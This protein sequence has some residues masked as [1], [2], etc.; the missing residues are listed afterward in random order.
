MKH[1]ESELLRALHA[2]AQNKKGRR[3]D[4]RARLALDEIWAA[5]RRVPHR[6][7]QGEYE[8]LVLARQLN[9][10]EENGHIAQ[11]K[12]RTPDKVSLPTGI[13]LRPTA[14]PKPPRPAMPAWHPDIYW[15][16]DA[17]PTA[18]A[19]QQ[20]AYTA[21]NAWLM[22]APD[23]FPV[24]LRER[25]LEIFGH[26]GDEDDFLMPEKTLDTLRSG[27]LFGDPG[28]LHQVLR[29]FTTHPP[30]LSEHFIEAVG[31]G[32]YQ[33]I[34]PGDLLLVVENSATWWSIVNTLPAVHRL[35]YV[36]WGLG[37]TFRASI[38]T[39]AQHTVTEIR[40]FGDLDLSGLRIPHG[41]SRTATQRGLPPVRP[42]NKLYT[43]LLELGTA[44]Q[45]K[46]PPAA[47]HEATD[48]T[49][50]LPE[51]LRPKAADVITRGRRLAQEWVGYRHLSRTDTWHSDV[52]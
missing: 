39:L 25:A 12:Q 1:K 28:K 22:S 11:F 19:R 43:A 50:W 17:W 9:T 32:Y 2:E 15:L 26:H 42:A 45:G 14:A 7:P 16:A 41:A 38:N 36:A 44:R 35:G 13:W 4:R 51:P 48:L 6:N 34:G 52:T 30:L 24:P 37:G 49:A 23:L 18:T 29:T 31:D 8:P 10:L 47:P 33:R 46:E 20:A 5:F 21:V 27:P 3:K 40:Y